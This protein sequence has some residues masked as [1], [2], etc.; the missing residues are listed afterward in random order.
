[1]YLVCI[2]YST[3]GK[4]TRL[5][6]PSCVDVPVPEKENKQLLEGELCCLGITGESS[7]LLGR[8]VG[9]AVGGAAAYIA[10]V[11]AMLIYCRQ[12]RQRLKHSPQHTRGKKTVVEH[13][14]IQT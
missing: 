8:T 1:M 5:V 3:T 7:Q 10:L 2:M 14:G 4:P 6:R 9:V 12:R 11:G 13:C